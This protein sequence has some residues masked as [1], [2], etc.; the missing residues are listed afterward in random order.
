LVNVAVCN[1]SRIA[2]LRACQRLVIGNRH[3]CVLRDFSV[4]SIAGAD[5]VRTVRPRS[6]C[7]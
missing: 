2:E 5:P 7:A 6:W 1:G 3:D 4:Y